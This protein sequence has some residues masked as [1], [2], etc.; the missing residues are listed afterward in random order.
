MGHGTQ[1]GE[2][3]TGAVTSVPGAEV[4]DV[5]AGGVQELLRGR[6]A[7][8]EIIPLP[9]GGYRFRIRG[10]STISADSPEPLFVVD[11][12]PVDV[13]GLATALSGLTRDDIQQVDVLKDVASTAIYGTRGAGGVVIINTRRR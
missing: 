11:G 5:R 12:T 3:V 13:A 8:L 6:V 2:K 7:G 10:M 4:G 1:P 9:D